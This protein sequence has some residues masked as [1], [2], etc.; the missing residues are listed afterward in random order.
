MGKAMKSGVKQEI[1]DM[2]LY[3]EYRPIREL[4]DSLTL[5]ILDFYKRESRQ[6]ATF[7][8]VEIKKRSC[9]FFKK[10]PPNSI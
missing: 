2:I 1:G 10:K 6:T 9:V 5:E 4:F 7:L 3:K 8:R